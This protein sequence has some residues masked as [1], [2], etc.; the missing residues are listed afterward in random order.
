[1]DPGGTGDLGRGRRKGGISLRTRLLAIFIALAVVPCLTL[2]LAISARLTRSIEFWGNPGVERTVDSSVGAA[3]VAL[4]ALKDH[5]LAAVEGMAEGQAPPGGLD[6]LRT[7]ERAGGRYVLRQAEPGAAGPLISSAEIEAALDASRVI[8]KPEGY[9]LAIAALDSAAL[10]VIVGGY[11]MPPELFA[12]IAEAR[13]GASLFDRLKLYLAVSKGWVWLSTGFVALLVV[14]AAV[15]L[16]RFMARGLTR[17]IEDLVGAMERLGRGEPVPTLAESGDPEMA[18]LVASFN[19]MAAEL[20]RS[21][22][23]LRRAERLAAWQDVARRVAHEIKNPL[24]PIQFAIHRLKKE[25]AAPG[26]PAPEATGSAAT[27]SAAAGSAAAGSAATAPAAAGSGTARTAALHESLDAILGEVESLRHMA[28]EFS[29]LAKLPAPE[30]APVAVAPLL[31][32]ASELFTHPAVEVRLDLPLD[33]PEVEADSRLLRQ[34]FANLFKNAIE[35]MPDGG[36]LSVR[37][38]PAAMPGGESGVAIEIADTGPGVP[39]EMLD[40]VGE[41]YLSTKKGGSGIG[42]AVVIKIVHDHRG[43]FELSNVAAGGAVARVLLPAGRGGEDAARDVTRRESPAHRSQ[44]AALGALALAGSAVATLALA[45]GTG[46]AGELLAIDPAAEPLAARIETLLPPDWEITAA[47]G[48]RAPSRWLGPANAV[49][50]RIEDTTVNIHHPD[51]HTYHPYI[52]LFFCPRGWSGTMEET[53]YYGDVTPAFLLGRNGMFTVFYQ[54]GGRL[55][56]TDA[57]AALGEAFALAPPRV[58]RDLRLEVDALAHRRLGERLAA[59]HTDLSPDVLGR[60]TGLVKNGSLLYLEYS[61][62]VNAPPATP[63]A[64]PLDPAV[65]GLIEREAGLLLAEAFRL[66]PE[67]EC[68]YVRRLCDN[69]LFDALVER[70]ANGSALEMKGPARAGG[71]G[72]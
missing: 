34:V 26:A 9:L 72:G 15:I 46:G 14:I 1:M 4:R 53:D 52:K 61:A 50:V 3:R 35:A 32:E 13:R 68:A 6:I 31:R 45:S 36:V 40:R 49:Y 2:T 47:A 19:R 63:G 33:L 66:Y 65:K 23:E 18:Y 20:E 58:G 7:Y 39:S 41:P 8:E 11:A 43:R 64:P 30:L 37:A 17:P 16:A 71:S 5:L 57:W 69:R 62:R 10:R 51:G 29:R 55:T 42:I 70:S 28:D 12:Q 59:V 60:V 25:L 56:W 21:R 67:L 22:R 54:T 24:T 38:R 48:Q 44:R 27:G